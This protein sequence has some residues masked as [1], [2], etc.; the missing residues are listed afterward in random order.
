[1]EKILLAAL[2]FSSSFLAAMPY[3][4]VQDSD[5]ESSEFWPPDLI[6]HPNPPWEQPSQKPDPND[7]R[8]WS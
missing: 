1:M 3:V 6:P 7:P 8:N 4:E 2:L 5:G